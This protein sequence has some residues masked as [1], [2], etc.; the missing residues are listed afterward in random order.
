[1]RLSAA[2]LLALA[3]TAFAQQ[4]QPA[5]DPNAPITL[6]Q[7][8]AD[9]DWIGTP[10]EAAWWSWDGQRAYT[11]RKRTGATIR[12]TWVQPIA[13]GAGAM[14]DGAARADM[15]AADPVYDAQRAR[16]A[17]VRNGDVFVR[18]LRSGALQQ[19]TRTNDDESQPQWGSDGG[20][21][22]RVGNDWFR[23]TSTGGL[24]QAAYVLAEKSPDAK[25]EA[26]DLRDRQLRLI[27]TLR[28]DRAQRDA[29]QAQD[30]AWQLSDPTRAP[31]PA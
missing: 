26:D 7:A 2:L 9:P 13:G 18:D 3:P 30:K 24:R 17:Y 22:W 15:D 10:I 23:W 11:Q 5:S 6:A 16:M 27:D 8:M 25:P 1:M 12:D 29:A 21:V 28:N 20:L 14:L 31:V 4:A 19:L